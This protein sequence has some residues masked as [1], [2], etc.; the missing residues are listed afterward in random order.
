MAKYLSKKVNVEAIQL[1]WCTWNEVCDFL[2]EIISETNPGRIS[3]SYSSQCG[4]QS[5]YIELTIPTT[6]A[7]C[8]VKH[9]DWIIKGALGDFYPMPPDV[10]TATYTPAAMSG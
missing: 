5:P 2:G 3:S 10:F 7:P 9:G 8:R 4:E 6:L 1:C